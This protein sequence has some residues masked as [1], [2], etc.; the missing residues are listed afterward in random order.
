MS[1]MAVEEITSCFICVSRRKQLWEEYPIFDT[2]NLAHYIEIKP[3]KRFGKPV[4]IGT[5]IAVAD[6]LSWLAHGMT[7]SDIIEDFPE[8]S[9]EMIKACLFY[10]ASREGLLGNA[11]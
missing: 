9:E 1:L 11:S 7:T 4:L 2:M 6:V 10:A 8:L 5:R 3:F